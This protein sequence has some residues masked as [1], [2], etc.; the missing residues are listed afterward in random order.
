MSQ[1]GVFYSRGGLQKISKTAI[2]QEAR[3]YCGNWLQWENF[4]RID[5]SIYSDPA[6]CTLVYWPLWYRSSA[7]VLRTLMDAAFEQ[8][9]SAPVPVWNGRHPGA[10]DDP[11]QFH[12]DELQEYVSLML[13]VRQPHAKP[14]IPTLPYLVYRCVEA[15]Y[16]SASEML[17]PICAKYFDWDCHIFVL[18][19]LLSQLN[20]TKPNYVF[21]SEDLDRVLS[22]CSS[23]W[24]DGDV[25][26][27]Y[28]WNVSSTVIAE[29][30]KEL[31]LEKAALSREETDRMQTMLERS[32]KAKMANYV[33]PIPLESLSE[34][35][36]ELLDFAYDLQKLFL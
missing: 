9:L 2:L 36:Q 33:K 7:L 32:R 11:L 27:P 28:E 12:F 35:N 1:Q 14:L 13:F 17:D 31:G 20:V 26:V 16:K 23:L 5:K 18:E 34:A 6:R 24:V 22:A 29:A 19:D 4:W 10:G 8:D 25:I 30:M 21:E 3:E 15:K